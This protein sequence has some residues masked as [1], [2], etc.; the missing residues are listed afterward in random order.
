MC[1]LPQLGGKTDCVRLVLL[2]QIYRRSSWISAIE[3]GDIYIP[4]TFP[5]PLPD[6]EETPGRENEGVLGVVD[7]RV[8]QEKAPG[9]RVTRT[10]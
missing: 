7:P 1:F 6:A 2:D 5:R 10:D 4:T 3:I 9:H 8:D